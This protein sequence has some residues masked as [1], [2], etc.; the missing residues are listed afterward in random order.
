M[1]YF[2][3]I[4]AT[5]YGQSASKKRGQIY[6]FPFLGSFITLVTSW[7]TDETTSQD[8]CEEKNIE[9]KSRKKIQCW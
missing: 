2:A 5:N 3:T 8:F 7:M 4:S 1:Q 9:K 6:F